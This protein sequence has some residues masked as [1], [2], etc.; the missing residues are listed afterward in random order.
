LRDDARQTALGA[1]APAI[2]SRP[3]QRACG[4][5]ARDFPAACGTLTRDDDAESIIL[6]ILF[7]DVR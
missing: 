3:A 2:E 4:C 6:F 7:I 5:F 1:T